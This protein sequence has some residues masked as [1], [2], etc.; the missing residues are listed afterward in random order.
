MKK[1]VL[2]SVILE[3]ENVRAVLMAPT[4]VSSTREIFEDMRKLGHRYNYFRIPISHE[5]SPTES[6]VDDMLHCFKQLSPKSPIIFSCGMGVGRTTYAMIIATIFKKVHS[7]QAKSSNTTLQLIYNLDKGKKELTI[8]SFGGN[9]F[10][11]RL[12]HEERGIG[13][14][15]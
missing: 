7:T 10:N 13:G 2:R 6:F 11:H 1:T 9:I 5:Q 14:A 8:Y 12:D 4:K 15:A 3:K